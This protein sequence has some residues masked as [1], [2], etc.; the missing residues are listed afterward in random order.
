MN[1]EVFLKKILLVF[2]LFLALPIGV[3]AYDLNNTKIVENGYIKSLEKSTTTDTNDACS[4]DSAVLGNVDCED[5][6]AWL[7]Q[8]ILNYIKI[9]G[10]SL[11]IVLS[12]IDYT[13]AIVTSDNDT[14]KKTNRRFVNRIIAAVLLFFIPMLTELV[15]NIIGITSST[16][17]LK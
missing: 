3:K 10:P 1:I 7:L 15:L 17:G 12:A 5:S 11:A 4:D 14:M 13:K 6:V 2:V 9:I 8:K 16:A